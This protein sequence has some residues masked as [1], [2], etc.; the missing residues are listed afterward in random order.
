MAYYHKHLKYHEDTTK[1]HK[2]SQEDIK[3]LK[4]LQKEMNTQDD[5]GQ[6]DPRYWTIKDFKKIYGEVLN[7]PDGI[8][9]FDNDGGAELGEYSLSNFGGI[10]LNKIIEVLKEDYGFEKEDFEY[11]CDLGTLKDLLTE[12]DCADIVIVEYEEVEVYTGVFLTQKAAEQH[13]RANHY[14]Y[15]EKAHTFAMTAW[16]NKAE[17][18][19]W[20]ILRTVEWDAILNEEEAREDESI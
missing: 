12:K 18:K 8:V 9:M 3:F 13:L 19:L 16:R 4:E 15:G 6:A 5:L 7:N 11:V 17:E 14:H 10:E 2:I 1:K 20:D